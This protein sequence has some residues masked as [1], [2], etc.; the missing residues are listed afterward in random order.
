MTRPPLE[1]LRVLDGQ[2]VD[3]YDPAIGLTLPE[4]IAW[5]VSV[6]RRPDD[7]GEDDDAGASWLRLL[8]A[9]LRDPGAPRLRTLIL[10]DWSEHALDPW[11]VT[12]EDGDPLPLMKRHA[13]RLARLE[14]LHVGAFPAELPPARGVCQGIGPALAKL[15]ALVRLDLHGERGWELVPAKGHAGL[16]A[17]VMH[18][19][20]PDDGPL[21]DLVEAAFPGLERLDLWLG[22]AVLESHDDDELGAALASGRFPRLR[23]LGLRG[24]ESSALLDGLAA[25]ELE[26]ESLAITHSPELGD[27]GVSRLLSA[28]WLPRLRRLDLRGAG[29]SAELAAELAG[30]GPEIVGDD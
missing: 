2:V 29:V 10:D 15:P 6:V 17:L 5:A 12:F 19:A 21:A 16:R 13:G 11:D 8:T 22:P 27:D 30:Q 24:L 1:V 25:H 7:G 23:E 14:R 26:L 3:C 9:L 28:R 4:Q 18:V 20:E